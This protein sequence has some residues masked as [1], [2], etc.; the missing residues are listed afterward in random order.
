MVK[1]ASHVADACDME[2]EAA[3]NTIARTQHELGAKYA[4]D[5]IKEQGHRGKDAKTAGEVY[6]HLL[7]ELFVEYSVVDNADNH[8]V[9]RTKG[10]PF[11][12][13][14]S[15][16]NTDSSKLCVIFGN[17]FV[18]GLCEGVNPR[19]KYNI[20]RMMSRGDPYCEECIELG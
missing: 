14:W 12:Q 10:C 19:L 16:A 13:E 20:T 6:I 9:V 2:G 11:L 1:Y 18:Q 7:Q 3:L 17:S 15:K 4:R 8:F 5:Q